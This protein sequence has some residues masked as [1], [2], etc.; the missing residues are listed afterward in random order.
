MGGASILGSFVCVVLR[1]GLPQFAVFAAFLAHERVV[2]ALLHHSAWSNTAISS[3]NR[4]EDRRCEMNTAVLSPTIL[5][6]FVYTSASATGSSAAVGSSSHDEGRVLIERAGQRDFLRL[7]AGNL[8]A[9]GIEVPV[10]RGI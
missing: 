9:F 3:Q 10:Q 7:A 6:K 1:L 5:L 8:H 4:Q 2:R